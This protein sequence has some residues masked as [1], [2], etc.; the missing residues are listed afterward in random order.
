M[1]ACWW[2]SKASEGIIL[3]LELGMQKGDAVQ[4]GGRRGRVSSGHACREEVIP[5]G[6]LLHKSGHL[7]LHAHP[8]L[9]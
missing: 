5:S 4:L 1:E 7:P 8:H 3:E 6:Y 2:E 9:G